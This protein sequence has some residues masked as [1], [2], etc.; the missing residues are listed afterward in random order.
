MNQELL[1]FS[2]QKQLN[3]LPI[4]GGQFEMVKGGQFDVAKGDQFNVGRGGQFAWFFQ[5]MLF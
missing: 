1:S 4:L 2:L 3:R 5:T